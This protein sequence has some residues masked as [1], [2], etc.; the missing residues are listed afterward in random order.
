MIDNS[1]GNNIN[2]ILQIPPSNITTPYTIQTMYQS[3]GV[4]TISTNH[5]MGTFKLDASNN[6][7][8]LLYSTGNGW[9]KINSNNTSFYPTMEHP[10]NNS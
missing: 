6:S 10:K 7:V 9:L 1:S 4:V 2:L 5:L 8:N 3:G